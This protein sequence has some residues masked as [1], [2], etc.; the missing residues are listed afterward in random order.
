[1]EAIY[2]E[3]C[4]ASKLLGPVT[5]LSNVKLGLTTEFLKYAGLSWAGAVDFKFSAT[6]N[7]IL[8]FEPTTVLTVSWKTGK[9]FV[10][11]IVAA[12]FELTAIIIWLPSKE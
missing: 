7:L 8:T 1:M 5:K 6:S 4:L 11:R 10:D 12:N 2:I 9:Y 3:A